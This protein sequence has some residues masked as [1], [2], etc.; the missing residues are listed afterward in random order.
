MDMFGGVPLVTTTEV[1]PAPRVTRDSL[2]K[3]VE[4]ELRA[5]RE[6]L[7]EKGATDY[8]RLTKG[9]ADAILANMYINAPV[10]QGSVTAA[11]LQRAPA[12]TRR[13]SPRPTACST[14]RTT[15]WRRSGRPT[16]RPRTSR[17]PS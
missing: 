10:F 3:F 12:G 17:R 16:S 11:G 2:F 7:P 15:R 6:A 9:A 4:A 13:R 8:G 5:A 14:T 1:Q